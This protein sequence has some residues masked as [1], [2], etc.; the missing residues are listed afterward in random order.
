MKKLGLILLLFCGIT[1][2]SKAQ[3]TIE[4]QVADSACVCLSMADTARIKTTPHAVKTECFSKA[5]SQNAE[6]I[7]KNYQTEQRREDDL[8]KQGI[9][10]SL[11][12]LVENELEKNCAAYQ[13]LKKYLPSYRESSK[14]G[15]KMQKKNG[16]SK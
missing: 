3:Q 13:F 11:F 14:A 9:G 6:A 4:A 12:I 15:N 16:G 2:I 5:I 7:R 8:E 10:G 1:T